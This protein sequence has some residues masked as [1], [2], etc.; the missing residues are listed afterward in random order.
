MNKEI[1]TFDTDEAAAYLKQAV[2]TL[3]MWRSKNTGPKFYK[4]SHKVIY[5]KEDLDEWIKSKD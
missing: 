1:I 4:P 5:Y 2:I 3:E